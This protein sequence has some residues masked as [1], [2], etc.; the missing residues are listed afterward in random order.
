MAW[1]GLKY[2]MPRKKA[3]DSASAS[4]GEA[5]PEPEYIPNVIPEPE[6]GDDGPQAA[7]PHPDPVPQPAL[8]FDPSE[9]LLNGRRAEALLSDPILSA[10][11]DAVAARYRLAWENSPRGDVETQ[12]VAHASLAALK[13]VIGAIRAFVGGAK[14]LEADLAA[15]QRQRPY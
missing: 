11:F 2:P 3:A 1:W 5:Q 15:K 14:I 10:A 13:D 9:R 8:P 4:M 6:G 7:Q 12:H